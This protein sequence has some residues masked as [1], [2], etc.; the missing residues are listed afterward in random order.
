MR[1]RPLGLAELLVCEVLCGAL[2]RA[3]TH[4]TEL[5]RYS[6]PRFANTLLFD[7]RQYNLKGRIVLRQQ[8]QRGADDCLIQARRLRGTPD[9][10]CKR[11]IVPLPYTKYVS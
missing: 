3:V 11:H 4:P 6:V 2:V 9:L 1:T 7:V 10:S 8:E 5:H